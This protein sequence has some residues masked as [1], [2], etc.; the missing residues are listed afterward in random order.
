MSMLRP[1]SA[2]ILSL[3]L[4]CVA[5]GCGGRPTGDIG[6]AGVT[7]PD[8]PKDSEAAIQQ[9]QKAAEEELR[10]GTKKTD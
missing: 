9:S 1:S 5:A 8:V 4:G 2:L 10:N 3:V 7:P 6:V